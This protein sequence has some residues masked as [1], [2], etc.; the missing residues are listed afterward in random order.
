MVAVWSVPKLGTEMLKLGTIL[1][2]LGTNIQTV[3][4]PYALFVCKLWF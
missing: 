1:G 3:I 4:G 2:S